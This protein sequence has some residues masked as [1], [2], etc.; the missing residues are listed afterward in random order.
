SFLATAAAAGTATPSAAP[1]ATF[2][3]VDMPSFSASSMLDLLG[4]KR[5]APAARLVEALDEARDDVLAD[6]I[7]PVLREV[8]AGGA[9]RILG[10]RNERVTRCLPA[11]RQNRV[12]HRRDVAAGPGLAVARSA[13][14]AARVRERLLPAEPG[15]TGRVVRLLAELV[16]DL[17]EALEARA[18]PKL[19]AQV[20]HELR[21]VICNLLDVFE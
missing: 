1:A 3:P 11:S 4:R 2:L 21:Q 20:V 15:H 18:V 5:S 10:G 6:E 9:G 12:E 17:D 8:L 16:G 7:G 19:L 13:L 14:R